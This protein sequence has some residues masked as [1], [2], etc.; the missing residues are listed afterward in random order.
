MQRFKTTNE[1]NSSLNK[2][3]KIQI[4]NIKTGQIDEKSSPPD[5]ISLPKELSI[6][7]KD[8]L[9]DTIRNEDGIDVP[10]MDKIHRVLSSTINVNKTLDRNLDLTQN[11]KNDTFYSEIINEEDHVS[12]D[13]DNYLDEEFKLISRK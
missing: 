11:S 9:N 8:S 10:K 13:S 3:I 7:N 2:K 1:S 4:S 5:W 12:E 6:E